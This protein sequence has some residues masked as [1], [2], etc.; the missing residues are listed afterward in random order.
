MKAR[1]DADEVTSQGKL[2]AEAEETAFQTQCFLL[3]L[4]SVNKSL[5]MYSRVQFLYSFTCFVN[6]GV[7]NKHYIFTIYDKH[8]SER[9]GEF[10]LVRKF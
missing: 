7:L 3:K 10:T 8:A 4:Y 5:F 6:H 9:H 1:L 2:K